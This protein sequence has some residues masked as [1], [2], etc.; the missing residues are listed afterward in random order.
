MNSKL[1]LCSKSQYLT[2]MTGYEACH[3]DI[4]VN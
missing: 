1:V 4:L 2:S 3:I